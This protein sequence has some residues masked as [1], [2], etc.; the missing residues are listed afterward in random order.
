MRRASAAQT[1]KKLVLLKPRLQTNPQEHEGHPTDRQFQPRNRFTLAHPVRFLMFKTAG[2]GRGPEREK[3]GL[4]VNVSAGGICLLLAEPLA[5][6]QVVKVS[7][8]TPLPDVHVHT[9]AEV[10][11]RRHLRSDPMDIYSV[12]MK[13]LL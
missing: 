13:F 11:W 5:L 10:R 9:L 8:P 12:G 2:G 3:V 6:R 4:A 1:S 7:I